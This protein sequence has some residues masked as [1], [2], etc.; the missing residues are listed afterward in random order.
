MKST[1]ICCIIQKNY[2]YVTEVFASLNN[3]KMPSETDVGISGRMGWKS[4]GTFGANK[5]STQLMSSYR[6]VGDQKSDSFEPLIWTFF[7]LSIVGS[8]R[9][10]ADSAANPVLGSSLSRLSVALQCN[11]IS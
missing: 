8:A 5:S 10:N 1:Q 3:Q 4:L 7:S 11:A 9:G 6:E 2:I